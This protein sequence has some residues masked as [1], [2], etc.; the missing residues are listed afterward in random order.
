MQALDLNDLLFVQQQNSVATYYQNRLQNVEHPPLQLY[1]YAVNPRDTLLRVSSRLMLPYATIATFNDVSQMQEP[2][3]GKIIV[4]PDRP[5]IFIPETN[6]TVLHQL[7]V[8]RLDNNNAIGQ[9][10]AI[11]TDDAP[12]LGIFYEGIDLTAYERSQF[13]RSLFEFP[14]TIMRLTSPFGI[15]NHPIQGYMHHHNGIDLGAPHGTPVYSARSGVISSIEDDSQLGLVITIE[16]D[17]GYISRYGHLSATYSKIGDN[18][19][20]N[21]VIGAVGNSGVSTGPHLHFEIQKGDTFINPLLLLPKYGI[22][23]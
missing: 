7:I 12:K 23:Q 2:L 18:V 13:L 22:I 11:T 21:S 10:I 17:F 5:G 16:H 15:R 19:D 3:E 20:P 4:I 8:R 9:K 14:L 6:R 1:E